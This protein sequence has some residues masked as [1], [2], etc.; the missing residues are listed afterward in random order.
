MAKK[1]ERTEYT[2]EVVDRLV[3]EYFRRFKSKNNEWAD[4]PRAPGNMSAEG[5]GAYYDDPEPGKYGRGSRSVEFLE[6]P[7]SW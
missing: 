1:T 6:D 4:V 5:W 2:P 3:K 7:S